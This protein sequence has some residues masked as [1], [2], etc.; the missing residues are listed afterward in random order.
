MKKKL[1][2]VLLYYCHDE[3]HICPSISEKM[4]L[5]KKVLFKQKEKSILHL[6]MVGHESCTNLSSK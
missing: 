3:N 6:C 4:S 5:T 1:S 2:S